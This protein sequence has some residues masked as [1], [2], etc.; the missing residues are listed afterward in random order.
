M[1]SLRLSLCVVLFG[2]VLITAH[3]FYTTTWLKLESLVS[4]MESTGIAFDSSVCSEALRYIAPE[5]ERL[6]GVV[7]SWAGH[8]IN[9]D[10]P[11]Q[12][13]T[14]LYVEKGVKPPPIAGSFKAVRRRDVDEAAT[15]EMS[16]SYLADHGDPD[17]KAALRALLQLRKLGKLRGYY[18]SLPE[19]VGTDGRI[20]ASMGP[21][22]ASGRLKV[23]RPGLQ[24]ISKAQAN[25]LVLQ[26]EVVVNATQMLRRAVVAPPGKVL[27]RYDFSALE[28]RL[29]GNRL[30]DHFG[31]FSI[32]A[33]TQQG[34]DPHGAT[35]VGLGK[36]GVAA[37]AQ[38]AELPPA[39]VKQR[40]KALREIA[41]QVGFS[42]NYGKT[43]RGLGL[44]CRDEKGEP[45]GAKFG[46]EL[47]DGFYRA[48]PGVKK[49][50]DWIKREAR[51]LEYVRSLLGRYRYLPYEANPQM[52]NDY[53]RKA[54]N[55]I[56][57]DAADVVNLAMLA[58]QAALEPMGGELVLQVHDELVAEVEREV[59]EDAC[60]AVQQAMTNCYDRLLCPLGVEG[61][62]G[63]D[64][65]VA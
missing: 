20:H 48:R 57:N 16:I 9:V 22:A 63:T 62:Y 3:D 36:A 38:C 49:W 26:N 28:W 4:R 65:T 1:W 47:L 23:R 56:Q 64:W 25:P 30:A 11:K 14:C 43:G 40:Y 5:I 58:V 50:H 51:R 41:K 12:V 44:A 60:Q 35:A 37:F 55:V 53:D 54:L 10:S 61:G 27:V 32:V 24:A 18:E 2:A 19:H 8:P 6:Q 13:A 33:E 39:E 15:S 7:D 31:D 17:T 34:I 42:I 59:A 29:L 21:E 45:L 52:Q 46:N